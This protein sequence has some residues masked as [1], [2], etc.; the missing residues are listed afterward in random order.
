M[1][2]VFTVG[3]SLNRRELVLRFLGCLDLDLV[4]VNQFRVSLDRFC[5]RIVDRGRG[6]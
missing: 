1:G 3:K 4:V 6:S 5:E 2:G